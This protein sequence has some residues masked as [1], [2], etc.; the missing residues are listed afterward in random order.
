MRLDFLDFLF[1]DLRLLLF[2]DFPPFKLKIER[3]PGADNARR[4]PDLPWS[5]L[6][7]RSIHLG[8]RVR[9]RVLEIL[10]RGILYN[11]T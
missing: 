6:K 2:L 10:L 4:R 11:I 1:V 5:I 9:R 8:E 3:A 7:A